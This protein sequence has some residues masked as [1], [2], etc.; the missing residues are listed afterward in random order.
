MTKVYI[1]V[2]VKDE[3]PTESG[4]YYT[5]NRASDLEINYFSAKN[6]VFMDGSAD[7]W[8]KEILIPSRHGIASQMIEDGLDENKDFVKGADY[9]LDLFSNLLTPNNNEQEK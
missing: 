4:D 8:L 5:I 2:S 3:L 1:P 9:I 7:A 6:K